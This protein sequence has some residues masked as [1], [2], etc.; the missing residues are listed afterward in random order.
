MSRRH[1]TGNS[2]I[3]ATRRG[4]F[5]LW[6]PKQAQGRDARFAAISGRFASFFSMFAR[7]SSLPMSCIGVPRRV[8][9][10]MD[11]WGRGYVHLVNVAKGEVARAESTYV[12]LC[13]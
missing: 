11:C 10:C 8:D 12:D 3:T 6:E 5:K 2:G 13:L 7:K 4:D 1:A 9:E